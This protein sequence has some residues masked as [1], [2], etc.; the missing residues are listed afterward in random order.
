MY[1]TGIKATKE[2]LKKIFATHGTPVQVETDNGPPFQPNEF[3]QFAAAEGFTHHRI[4]PLH[5]SANGEAESFIR[6]INKTEQRAKIQRISPM[7]AMQ[8]MLVGYRSTPHPATGITPYEGMMLRIVRTKLNYESRIS[9]EPKNEKQVN[10]HDKQYKEKVNQ[11]AEN[12]N[13]KEH[14][15]HIG[16]QVFLEQLKAN[17]WSAAYER[18]I[19]IVYK[20]KG[21]T[22]YARRKRDERF[23]RDSSKF[24]LAKVSQQQ[25][26][27]SK[28]QRSRRETLLRKT[29]RPIEN[30]DVAAGDEGDH[31]LPLPFQQGEGQDSD[32][33]TLV[34]DE[35]GEEEEPLAVDEEGEDSEDQQPRRSGRQRQR[36]KHLKDFT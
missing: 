16:D 33:E 28:D 1:S 26:H 34:D 17:K 25:N 20:I 2:K 23:S 5:P 27:T 30:H 6:L 29:R 22:I 7:T 10:E 31:C 12:K 19:Y 11:N 13:T 8:D 3:A 24:R 36:P 18:D 9:Y 35:T 14:T 4:T 15:F 32:N 21:S